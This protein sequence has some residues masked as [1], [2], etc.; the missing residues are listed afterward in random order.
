MI[1]M[2]Y[3]KGELDSFS[4]GL[5]KSSAQWGTLIGQITFGILADRYGRKK[6]Y[7][8]EL[9]LII[10]ATVCCATSSNFAA[11]SG[12]IGLLTF[13]RFVLGF[14]IGGDYPLS[15]VITSEFS[16]ANNRGRMIACV[17]AMQGIGILLAA[18]VT[19]TMLAIFRS[20]ILVDVMAVDYVW[21]CCL[22]FGAVPAVAT[23]YFRLTMTES[24][25]FTADVTGDAEKAAKDVET[26]LG[27]KESSQPSMKNPYSE[28]NIS[29]IQH[30]SNY[31]I[32]DRDD[33]PKKPAT[34][35]DF[36]AHFSQWNQLKILLGTS[37]SWFCL[38]VAFYGLAL[39]QSAVLNAVGYGHGEGFEMLWSLGLGN[40][41]IACLGTGK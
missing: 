30:Q 16:S 26:F 18:L 36:R 7:G 1:S 9:M 4:D 32:D 11:G 27:S 22:A 8:S 29:H 12:L 15:A 5:V 31:H 34:F 39:N 3:F 20:L 13:W 19:V 6:M 23:L 28:S 14:G 40:L 37:I 33:V 38:D 10:F 25:R 2:V 17:F 41:V 21:R 35:A 24:P